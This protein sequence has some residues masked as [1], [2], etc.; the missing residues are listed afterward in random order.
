MRK[1]KR[2]G[3][4]ISIEPARRE[5]RFKPV[6]SWNDLAPIL[7]LTLLV[8]ALSLGGAFLYFVLQWKK[9]NR[10]FRQTEA[11]LRDFSIFSKLPLTRAARFQRPALWLAIRSRNLLA[12]QE[13]LGLNNPKPCTWTEG[14]AS[15]QK[16]FIAPPL[17]G[18]IL[19]VGAGLPNPSD[20]VDNCFRFLHDLSR[21]LGH[22][23]F[24][25]ANRVLSE[26]AWVR[27]EAG[28]VVRAYAWAGKTQWN[29][30]VKTP[31]ELEL[32][33]KCFHYLEA[34]ER[35][36]FAQAE[37]LAT[38]TEKVSLLAGRWSLDPATI[39]ER[40]FEHAP[41]IVGEPSRLY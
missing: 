1:A 32:S 2:F 15:E 10:A 41:G 9:Q 40:L 21:K 19:V 23:Q 28:R 5:D 36:S 30:G 4:K 27:M 22:V 13:A 26:H 17:N 31:A 3:R 11:W 7:L 29:Q 37:I 39:D 18:W 35:N 16:L 34:P 25:H 8:I 24:F 6:S 14:I 20:D 33:L 12:V 38:N